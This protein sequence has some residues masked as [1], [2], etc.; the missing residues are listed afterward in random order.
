MPDGSKGLIDRFE[1][2][3]EVGWPTD[4]DFFDTKFRWYIK[5]A[6]EGK[7]SKWYWW[8][9][10]SAEWVEITTTYELPINA[11]SFVLVKNPTLSW[12]SV[13]L[14]I[15]HLSHYRILQERVMQQRPRIPFVRKSKDKIVTMTKYFSWPQRLY[16]CWFRGFNRDPEVPGFGFIKQRESRR[17]K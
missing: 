4:A 12:E 16:L 14:R 9:W 5:V 11:K 7:V 6:P 13:H 8:C 15:R 3:Q 2:F 10:L 1:P 17:A